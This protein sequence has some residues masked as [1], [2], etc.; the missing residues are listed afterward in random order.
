MEGTSAVA[1]NPPLPRQYGPELL[2]MERG[3]GVWLY[4][5]AGRR[6]LDFAGGIA[7]NSLGYG[8]EDLARAAY[9]QMKRLPHVSNLY[10][11]QPA[12]A[13][14]RAMIASGRFAAA[15]FGNSG[16]EA[17]EAALKY[18]RLYAQRTRGPGHEKLLCFSNAFHGRTFGALSCTPT[19][20]YQ[21]PF[22]PLLPGVVTAP[23][24]DP[25]ALEKML[26][27]GFAGVIVEVIQGE[28]GLAV[29]TPDF[30]RA[31][32]RL[33]RKHDVILIADE[34]QTGLARTGTLYASQGVGLEP[35]IITLAKPLAGGLPLSAALIPARVN[36]VLHP[37]E[38]GT[39]FGGGPVT[40]AVA[41]KVWDIV[42]QPAF[43]ESVRVKGEALTAA[44]SRLKSA[45]PRVGELRGR[46]LLQGFEYVPAAGT[47]QQE[48]MKRL[49]ARMQEKGLLALRS[50]TNMVRLA[51]PLIMEAEEMNTGIR[52]IE[53]ALA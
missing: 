37:G 11:T 44:L 26:G 10:A 14:A 4:D 6:Y 45:S 50:G 53:E 22:A 13:L 5:A 49:L 41:L 3:E 31:L 19:A 20:K 33:C 40:T 32:N 47:D 25:A 27:P 35:D 23:Y 39:T 42:T 52:I 16:A 18:A 36:D 29:M 46:G 12:L 34:V 17:N 51:P 43:M 48:E 8:R 28:G 1:S 15:F 30:A 38:H 9:E 2:V 7:V 21:E 24:N